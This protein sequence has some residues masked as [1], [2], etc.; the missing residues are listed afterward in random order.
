MSAFSLR[1]GGKYTCSPWVQAMTAKPPCSDRTIIIIAE[2]YRLYSF[3]LVLP[4]LPKVSNLPQ[5]YTVPLTLSLSRPISTSAYELVGSH[6]QKRGTARCLRALVLSFSYIKNIQHF[7]FATGRLI[8]N[9]ISFQS[10]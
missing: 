2:I 10:R 8:R 5:P 4:V 3:R 6:V 9:S 1:A 7:L